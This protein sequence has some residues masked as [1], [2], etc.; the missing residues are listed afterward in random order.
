M[1]YIIM[2]ISKLFK[3]ANDLDSLEYYQ[4][5]KIVDQ[6]AEVVRQCSAKLKEAANTIQVIESAPVEEEEVYIREFGNTVCPHGFY[7]PKE[8]CPDCAELALQEVTD[9]LKD[10]K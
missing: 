3:L 9:I 1:S 5:A 10:P 4:A 6:I 8:H 2:S 7:L